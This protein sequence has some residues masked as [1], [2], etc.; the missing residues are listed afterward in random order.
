M[1]NENIVYTTQAIC[2]GHKL[3]QDSINEMVSWGIADPLGSKPGK[4]LFT[5]KDSDRIG[6]ALRFR[7]EL[8]IN[9][10]GAALALQLL[11][12]INTLRNKGGIDHVPL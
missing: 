5:Q 10:P 2:H 7:K 1:T 8:D 4:W 6:R 9:I 11:E 12:E 3:N